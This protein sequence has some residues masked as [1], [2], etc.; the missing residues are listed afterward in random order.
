MVIAARKE[1]IGS[2]TLQAKGPIGAKELELG[3]IMTYTC[4]DACTHTH[5]DEFFRTG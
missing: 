4:I 5:G 3:T 1:D 2:K